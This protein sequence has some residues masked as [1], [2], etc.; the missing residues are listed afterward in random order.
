M[1]DRETLFQ[2]LARKEW[3]AIAKTMYR[4]ANLIGSDPIIEQAIRLF[5]SEFF[6]ETEKLGPRDRLKS[7]EYPGLIIELKQHVFSK[8]FIGRL[9]DEKLKLLKAEKSDSLISY[10]ASHQ[11]R[12][13]AREILSEIDA[14]TP[15]VIADARREHVSV[16]ATANTDG[17]ALTRNLFKSKQEQ[18][19]FEA[20]RD[21]FPTYHPYPNVAVSS[22]LDFDALKASLDRAA[23]DYF[24]WA[25]IDC[26]V[27]DTKD[28]YEPRFFFELDSIYHDEERA[29]ENDALKDRIFS[30]ANVKL[31]RIR[32]RERSEATVHRFKQLVLEVM[33]GL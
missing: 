22:V 6:S 26:V 16:R 20:V 8:Q 29:R 2:M 21:A 32:A 27:F 24:F 11:D 1:I 18:N 15:E 31:I 28:G 5:E 19:F 25:I 17:R 12:P 14:K 4:N 3:D 30:A 13:L 23:R 33:R 10:A 9:V 7:Y